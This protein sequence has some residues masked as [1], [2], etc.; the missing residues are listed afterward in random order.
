MAAPHLKMA[1][2]QAAL[3]ARAG[4]DPAWGAQLGEH[5]LREC[6]P[7]P[8]QV[9]AGFWPLPGEIDIRPLL[10]AL[11]ERGHALVL[12]ATPPRGQPLTFH[13]WRPGDTLIREKFGTYRPEGAQL[14]PDYLLVPL[15]AFDRA[16]RRLG[17]GAGFYDRTLVRLPG[18][19]TVG[20][21]FAA[22]ELPEVPT[23]AD[24]VALD[25]IA[26]ERGVIFAGQQRDG[27]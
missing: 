6:P 19:R 5:V 16:G 14:D 9:V 10:L 25:A 15:L 23:D 8:G 3:L 21:A 20:C 11:A 13:R 26:T 1:A 22:Q 2:R 4:C 24:D 27:R 7:A 18:R 17:Y 12:P